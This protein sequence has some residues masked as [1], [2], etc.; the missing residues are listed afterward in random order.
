[1]TG[2][3]CL[4]CPDLCPG[5][6][7][8][9]WR[10]VSSYVCLSSCLVIIR[11]IWYIVIPS[12][13]EKPHYEVTSLT[14]CYVSQYEATFVRNDY[15]R[16]WA[17]T[18]PDCFAIEVTVGRNETLITWAHVVD[19]SDSVCS[20]SSL[21]RQTSPSWPAEQK[22]FA[23][24]SLL[25]DGD[26]GSCLRCDI[27]WLLLENIVEAWTEATFTWPLFAQKSTAVLP[28]EAFSAASPRKTKPFLL[29]TCQANICFAIS[30]QR[31][32]T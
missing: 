22:C 11:T 15:R 21:H 30:P 8:H 7:L 1:V 6:A 2:N 12:S 17:K 25:N 10:W 4:R 5:F 19:E 32:T 23:K 16:H 26:F 24:F 28:V 3:R 29:L 13:A 31:Q 27:E 20:T 18:K 14:S 9:P